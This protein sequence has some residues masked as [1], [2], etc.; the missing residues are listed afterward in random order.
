LKCAAGEDQLDG[1]SEKRRSIKETRNIPHAIKRR[2]AKWVGYLLHK[3]CLLTHVIEGNIEGRI[4]GTGIQG[5]KCKQLLDKGSY[6]NLKEEALECNVWRT[7]C[8][9]VARQASNECVLCN[10][11]L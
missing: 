11:G 4:E 8:G 3:N 10:T 1:L 9:S 2:K 6:W 5:E 7:C